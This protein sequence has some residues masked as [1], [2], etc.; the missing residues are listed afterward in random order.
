MIAQKY[1]Y[2][3]AIV[4]LFD[5][6]YKEYFPHLAVSRFRKAFAIEGV[7]EQSK[8]GWRIKNYL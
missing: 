8:D 1:G 6:C 5:F 7:L 3:G 2:A 4:F